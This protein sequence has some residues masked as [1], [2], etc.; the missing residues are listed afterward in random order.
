MSGQDS[1][2]H[3]WTVTQF[4]GYYAASRDPEGRLTKKEAMARA[5]RL[6]DERN[7]AIREQADPI[8]NPV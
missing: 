7:E 6:N 3:N 2:H 1:T 8:T 4:V 5:R